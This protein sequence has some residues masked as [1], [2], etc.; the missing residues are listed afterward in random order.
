M[1]NSELKR[2][3]WVVTIP[4]FIKGD[5]SI[6]ENGGVGYEKDSIFQISCVNTPTKGLIDDSS[7]IVFGIKTGNGIRARALRPATKEEIRAQKIM[8]Y[9]IY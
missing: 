8:I 7:N 2:D 5:G 9:E 4:G 3:M 1:K 6:K